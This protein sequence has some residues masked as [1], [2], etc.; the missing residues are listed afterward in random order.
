MIFVYDPEEQ[1]WEAKGDFDEASMSND[2][3]TFIWA[4][5]K[6]VLYLLRVS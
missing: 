3:V 2:E 6:Q 1:L 5:N 4:N